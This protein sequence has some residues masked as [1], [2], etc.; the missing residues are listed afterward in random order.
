TSLFP[1][2]TGAIAGN[3]PGAINTATQTATNAA[4]GLDVNSIYNSIVSA[5]Q[6][7][8]QE[9]QAALT[10]S[11]GAAGMGAS[12]DAL[13]ATADY[14]NQFSANL[15]QQLQTMQFQNEGLELAG[16]QQ[17]MDT[18][19]TAGMT[20]APSAA[21]VG[22]SGGPSTFSQLSSAGASA[23]EI[24]LMAV[25]LCWI[26]A[27]LYGGWSSPE[28]FFLRRLITRSRSFTFLYVKFGQRVAAHIKE[29]KLS[30]RIVKYF[31]DRL[32]AKIWREQC[33]KQVLSQA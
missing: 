4:G 9:G 21:V 8:R 24:A 16:S 7:Q 6:Q 22:Q 32:L 1:G 25:A 26:A 3:A 12:S 29:H 31:F 28:V 19:A 17:L 33:L 13:R 30:R 11:M 23:A 20:Y 14:Q 27:E 2:A 18:Y 10:S 15:L 5:S